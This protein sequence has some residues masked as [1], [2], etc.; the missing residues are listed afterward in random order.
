MSVPSST[1]CQGSSVIFSE[2][3]ITALRRSDAGSADAVTPMWVAGEPVLPGESYEVRDPYRG[4]AVGRVPLAREADIVAAIERMTSRPI[5]KL[6]RS[7]RAAILRRM[8]RIF[9]EKRDEFAR[10]AT[11][12]GADQQAIVR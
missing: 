4:T 12:V 11:Q 7:E 1:C 9:G 8:A 10:L 2:A 6:S 5:P 3:M